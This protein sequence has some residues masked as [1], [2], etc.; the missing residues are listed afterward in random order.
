MHYYILKSNKNVS[1][2]ICELLDIE[3]VD[4]NPNGSSRLVK[5]ETVEL[6]QGSASNTAFS[7]ISLFYF[8]EENLFIVNY[9]LAT[10]KPLFLHC[11]FILT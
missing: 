1:H 10:I 2:E 9:L 11:P 8:E 7:A 6:P 4:S 3:G 5:N